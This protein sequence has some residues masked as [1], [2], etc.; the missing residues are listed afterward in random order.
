[1][2][3]KLEKA[4]VVAVVLALLVFAAGAEAKAPQTS[5][6]FNWSP[7]VCLSSQTYQINFVL[8]DFGTTVL[9]GTSV[10]WTGTLNGVPVSGVSPYTSTAGPIAHYRGSVVVPDGPVVWVVTGASLTLPGFGTLVL[11][12]P[13][14]GDSISCRPLGVGVEEFYVENGAATWFVNF[15]SNLRFYQLYAGT[16]ASQTRLVATVTPAHPNGG[17]Y[18]VSIGPATS[19]GQWYRLH[20]VDIYG[21][22]EDFG[23]VQ[24][25]WSAQKSD[26][27]AVITLSS[28]CDLQQEQVTLT[29]SSDTASGD[30]TVSRDEQVI[31][32]V[33][34]QDPAVDVEYTWIVPG[35][36]G[37]YTVSDGSQSATV[38]VDC[39]HVFVE[40]WR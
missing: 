17:E 34:S 11:A 8:H 19:R 37:E 39:T 32:T 36:S 12:N 23:P 9:T 6:N 21:Q 31:G 27:P 26:P 13:G 29:W 10:S 5:P 15:E 18:N 35:S 22:S 1:M 14:A 33:P 30:W 20:V 25:T 38:T 3:T 28:V 40:D 4:M 7:G 2:R 16:E 24:A